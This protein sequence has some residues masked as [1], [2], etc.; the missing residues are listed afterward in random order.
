MQNYEQVRV[1]LIQMLEDL[2]ARLDKITE[3]IKHPDGPVAQDFAEQ[4]TENENNE[5]LD[6][7][8]N[9]TREKIENIKRALSRMEQGEYGVC[10][11]CGDAISPQRLAVLPF[12]SMCVKCA[13]SAEGC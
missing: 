1:Q 10:S 5:V 2:D 6:A 7:L 11:V 3:E 9:S 12:A 8:G 13:A 4:A